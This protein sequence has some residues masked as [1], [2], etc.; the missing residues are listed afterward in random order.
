MDHSIGPLLKN[1]FSMQSS[2]IVN[3]FNSKFKEYGFKKKGLTWY[4][5]FPECICVVNLQK[6]NYN[7]LYYL[8]VASYIRSI[9]PI[10]DYP[11]EE[12]C[13]IRTRLGDNFIGLNL[14]SQMTRDE[15]NS[16]LD[17][18]FSEICERINQI[19]HLKGIITYLG[20]N[21]ILRNIM[22]IAAKNLLDNYQS[23]ENND[24]I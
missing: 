12:K 3:Y 11:K 7:N 5:K 19:N 4:K 15:R 9:D 22:P 6:S 23:K 21:P 13:H 17:I 18:L 2:E 8:N 16:Y 10:I 1:L 24:I 14:S 20:K